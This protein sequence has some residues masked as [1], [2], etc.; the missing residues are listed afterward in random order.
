MS[1]TLK[2]DNYPSLNVKETS[3]LSVDANP[4]ATSLTLLNNNNIAL[5]DPMLIGSPGSETAEIRMVQ[6]A[7]GATIVVTD[8]LT[9]AHRAFDPVTTLIGNQ[10]KVYRAANVDGTQPA[11]GSFAVFSGS[12]VAIDPDQISTTFTDQAGSSAYWYKYTFVN[13]VTLTET[14]LADSLAVRGGGYA[15]YCSVDDIRQQASLTNNKWISDAAVSEKRTI[16][17]AEIDA[18]LVGLYVVPFVAPI[19]ALIANITA[20]L[21]AGLL[22]TDSY[23]Q[24][25]TGTSQNGK[26]K[27]TDARALLLRVSTK[28]LI[29]TNVLGVGT[30]QDDANTVQ[31]WPNNSTADADESQSGG[32][33]LFR[34]SHRF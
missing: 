28:D 1:V 21:A 2:L 33:H 34:I 17:Q 3:K 27:L 16:A 11:D 15:V 18:A 9:L 13:S 19:N 10:L 14:S 32:D 26:Q 7:T 5:N 23:G 8:A 30:A 31:S 25:T 20:M 6:S 12:T 29:L 24:N 4:T 22:L